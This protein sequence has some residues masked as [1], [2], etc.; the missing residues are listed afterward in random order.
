M[1]IPRL[2]SG[3]VL[4]A[5]MLATV[6]TGGSILLVTMM[7]VSLVGTF[8]LLRV[9]QLH[10]G[11]PGVLVYAATIILYG[12]L[13]FERSDTAL[14]ATGV[15]LFLV[16]MACYVLGYPRYT[17]EQI[18]A[19]YGSYTYAA[20][21]LSFVYLL[22]MSEG[23]R[24]MVWLIFLA[25]WGCD[26]CAYCVGMLFKLCKAKTH[27]MSPK[28][29]PKKTMEGAVGGLVGVFLL[30]FLYG[31]IFQEQI[32]I[33]REYAAV[34]CG[35]ICVCGGFIAMI[36]DLAASAIKRNHDI[37]DY[38]KLIPG[39]GGVMDR[40]DSILFVAP[41]IYFAAMFLQFIL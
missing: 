2:I 4:V 3:I 37:K 22:R 36:G 15:V 14:Y 24:Y 34:S 31:A 26:T 30:G 28:L 41:M 13:Y 17:G 6:S 29:S 18:F 23:G 10:R 9:L 7:L 21:L 33:F 38:G 19:A 8:E 12:M 5:L 20:V 11:T 27:K 32:G 40:F 16:L 35:M 25:S 1:F 39:H